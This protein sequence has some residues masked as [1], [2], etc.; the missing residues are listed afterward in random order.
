MDER[1]PG[2][3]RWALLLPAAA[4]V[5][6]LVLF[7]FARPAPPDLVSAAKERGDGAEIELGLASRPTEVVVLEAS[8]RGDVALLKMPTARRDVSFY[9]VSSTSWRD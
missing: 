8:Q 2:G 9:L 4:L 5:A 3:R 7:F 1:A 6:G